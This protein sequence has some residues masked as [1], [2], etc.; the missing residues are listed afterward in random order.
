MPRRCPVHRARP[1]RRVDDRASAAQRGYDARHRA[2]RL[3]WLA[4]HPLCGDRI[5]PPAADTCLGRGFICEGTVLSHIVPIS[6]GGARFEEGNSETLCKQ[7][8][9]RRTAQEDGGFGR[10]DRGGSLCDEMG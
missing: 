7:C 6:Q 5:G 8:H 9:D 10:G 2:Y 3:F 4:R 1:P